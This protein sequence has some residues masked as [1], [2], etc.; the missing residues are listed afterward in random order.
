MNTEAIIDLLYKIEDGIFAG[1]TT[2]RNRWM[3]QIEEII[4]Q[5]SLKLPDIS[6]IEPKTGGR[7]GKHTAHLQ[8]LLD[9]MAEVF[10]IDPGAH[11]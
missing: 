2:L 9:E 1:E 3:E 4:S 10:R 8:T 11:W 5:T 7:Y 6:N